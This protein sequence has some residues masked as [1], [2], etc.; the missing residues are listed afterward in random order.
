MFQNYIYVGDVPN[1]RKKGAIESLEIFNHS[2]YTIANANEVKSVDKDQAVPDPQWKRFD[3]LAP[4][5]HYLFVT[6]IELVTDEYEDIQFQSCY[7]RR[8]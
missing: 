7:V 2:R 1:L 8:P 6:T 5:N 3:L 4:I